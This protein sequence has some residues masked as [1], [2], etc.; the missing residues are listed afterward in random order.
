MRTLFAAAGAVAALALAGAAHAEVI[1]YMAMMD[2]ASEVPAH[3]VPGKGMVTAELDTKTKTF[4]YKADFSG[5]SGPATMAHFHGPA[6]PGANAGPVVVF[7]TP[8]ASPASGVAILTD[9]QIADLNS[10]KWYVNVH[11]DANK[12]GEIRGQVT[13]V[14]K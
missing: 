3:T 14:A 8:V 4:T 6:L 5:L 9:A 11:T 1:H 12:G 7:T 13:K 10:G 2:G